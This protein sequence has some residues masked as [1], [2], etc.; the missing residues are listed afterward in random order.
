[1]QI[2]VLGPAPIMGNGFTVSVTLARLLQPEEFVPMT[3]YVVVTVGLAVADVQ[4]VQESPVE[5]VHE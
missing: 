1:M 3:L 4:V 2:A 5:G